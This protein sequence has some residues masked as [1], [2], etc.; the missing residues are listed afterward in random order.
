M[1]PA[2]EWKPGITLKLVKHLKIAYWSVRDFFFVMWVTLL[3]ALI[4]IWKQPVKKHRKVRFGQRLSICIV[5][6]YYYPT[7]G[8]ITE[9]VYNLSRQLLRQGH[10]VS[11]LTSDAG[12]DGGRGN[13][14]GLKIFH[15]GRSR[16]IYSNG[17][18]A[19]VT[20]GWSLHRQ[21]AA[22]FREQHFD[23]VHIHSPWTPTLPLLCMKYA[24][25]PVVGTFHTDFD[26]SRWLK[27]WRVGV[28]FVMDRIDGLIAVSP[29]AVR[30]CRRFI[31]DR[32]RFRVVPN[33][34][35]TEWYR[36]GRKIPGLDDGRPNILCIGR[37]DPR[38]GFSTVIQAFDKLRSSVPKARL[39][40]VGYGPL[41]RYYLSKV[42]RHLQ[43][44]ICF[45]GKMDLARQKYYASCDAMIVTARKATTSIAV[46]EALATET[47]IVASDID[48]H[49]FFLRD[50]EEALLVPATDS[51]AYA[52]ALTRVLTD[53]TLRRRLQTAGRRRAMAMDWRL[54]ASDVLDVYYDVLEAVVVEKR[55]SR[56]LSAFGAQ[57]SVQPETAADVRV[58]A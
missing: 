7:L 45:V 47:A 42:P 3:Y 58:A 28:Q 14:R 11:I 6:E 37:F 1:A 13:L 48:G 23:I 41:Q 44:D 19:R 10:K 21:V 40:I 34:V 27:L 4:V 26:K 53:D 46:L 54:V 12:S 52:A 51:D 2:N 39:V 43:A 24:D 31:D 57:R 9:H 16:E 50:G 25:C 15:V 56:E 8:G 18:I 5:T 32:G 22:I 38:N 35:D 20:F 30:S 49:R 33:G 17:S 55:P 36:P 29:V